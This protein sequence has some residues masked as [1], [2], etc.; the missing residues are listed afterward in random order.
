MHKGTSSSAAR[1]LTYLCR[2]IFSAGGTMH[3]IF[4]APYFPTLFLTRFDSIT[5]GA[6][7][8]SDVASR[9]LTG[10]QDHRFQCPRSFFIR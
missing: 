9:R 1:A 5:L 2:L 8:T 10:E 6:S 7:L 4:A 3:F